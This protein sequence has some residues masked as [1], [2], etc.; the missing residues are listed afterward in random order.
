LESCSKDPIGYRDAVNQ[1][2]YVR[3]SPSNLIDP[4]G[5]HCI[6]CQWYRFTSGDL[7][8]QLG[9][10]IVDATNPFVAL[11][12]GLVNARNR[13]LA[14]LKLKYLLNSTLTTGPISATPQSGHDGNV[15]DY[16]A[17]YFLAADV[18]ESEPGDCKVDFKESDLWQAEARTPNGPYHLI[19]VTGHP[20]SIIGATPSA[21][22]N[23]WLAN[24]APSLRCNKKIIMADFTVNT[25]TVKPPSFKA[26]GALQ[27]MRIY[28]DEGHS[29]V[30]RHRFG[31]YSRS[32][33]PYDVKSSMSRGSSQTGDVDECG[34]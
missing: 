3:S 15:F 29:S 9:K 10:D 31:I 26:W 11:T 6:V 33:P 2:Q 25:S 24:R 18:C 20:G 4:S 22:G 12:N 34:C 32:V 1:Y 23:P 8:E 7:I 30:M 28:D 19:P 13:Q 21:N 17:I 27:E 14:P 16:G 5:L